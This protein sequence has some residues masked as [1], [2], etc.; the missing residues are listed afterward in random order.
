MRPKKEKADVLHLMF[1]FFLIEATTT[2]YHDL[3]YQILVN[4]T[5]RMRFI[6]HSNPLRPIVK[7]KKK[8]TIKE[9]KM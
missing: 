9:L 3:I 1:F 8:K 4:R 6:H 5:A 7:K 2:R